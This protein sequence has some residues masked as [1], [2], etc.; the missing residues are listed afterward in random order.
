M[1]GPATGGVVARSRGLRVL[2]ALLSVV[3]LGTPVFLLAMAV[4][5]NVAPLLTADQA[6]IGWATALT[7]ATG[8]APLL[9]VLQAVSHP[10][11]AYAAVTV[12][13]AW[14]WIAKGFRGRAIW[15]LSTVTATWLIGE[16]LKLVVRRA[17]P[18]LESPWTLPAGYS[19]PSGHALNIT[20]AAAVLLVL[21]WPLWRHSGRVV[22]VCAAVVVVVAVGLDRVLLGVHYPSDVIAGYVLGL[23]ITFASWTGFVGPMRGTSSSASSPPG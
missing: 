14:A 15:A 18:T 8:L 21:L 9:V 4:R 17:R 11:V 13:A 5:L 20:V 12:V 6:A 7:A 22:A 1:E 23:C 16:L 3:A 2:R 19:F 10:L